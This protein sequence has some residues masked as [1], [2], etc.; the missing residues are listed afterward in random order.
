MTEPF[1]PLKLAVV[2]HTNVGKTSL[3]RTLTRDVGFGEVSHRPSTTRHVEGARLSVDGQAL[4]ELYDT[5]GLEDAI[6][7]L[8]YLERL[9][10]PGER[11]DG[12]ARL[13]RFLD[14]SEARQ[15]FEQEAKVLRQL[16]ASDAGLYVIDARE[17]VLAKYRDELEVLAS[18]G[19]PLLPVLN[20][21]S[22]AQHREPEWREALARLGLHALV[23]FDSVAPPEDGE[24][25]LYESLAL[26]LESARGQL[27]RLIV[28]QQAQRLARQ[29]SAKRLIAELLI[30]CAAC[31]R[32][33]ASDADLEHQA[34]SQLRDAV[35][36]R[37]QRCVEALLKLYAFRAQDAA[38]SDLPLLDGRWGDDLFNPDT[39]KQLGVRVGGGIAA[40]A[41]A[42]A[43]V[44]LL[45]GGLTL[46]AAALAGAIAGG[47]LQT[48]RSYG[49]RLMGKLKGQRELTVD[50]SVLRLLALRQRQLLQAINQRGHAAMDSIRIATPQ[51][52]TW[53]EG[54]LPEALSKARAYPQWSSLNA[55]PRL[56]QA[57]RQEQIEQLAGQL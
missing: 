18:C 22:S 28:D 4:L 52:K 40:G 20:F 53:R 1:K 27:E 13:A 6:A 9:E 10:R 49:N 47:A 8:D 34:I 35:R 26:L 16:L 30:D 33:V 44:D 41:A 11:L 24:R 39:L 19:K 12:P 46:G 45:V 25:R 54:K 36:Q 56:S 48:A 51:D 29:Q 57:E 43:G 23:R 31:R 55:N 21:V 42:G 38:A 15:R 14:G 50:D 3:L 2:G 5:P 7:L 37:E 32:S 17:P